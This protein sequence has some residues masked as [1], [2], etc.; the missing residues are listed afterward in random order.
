MISSSFIERAIQVA[1]IAHN[2]QVDLAGKPYILHP[3]RVMMA[4]KSIEENIVGVLHDVVEDSMFSVADVE[5]EFG[6]V[7]AAAVDALSRRDGESYGDFIDRC[8]ENE[9]ARAVKLNDI[10]DNMDPSRKVDDPKGNLKRKIR[11]LDALKK[12]RVA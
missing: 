2:G 8:A 3:L 12:L 4:G 11:Y 10:A 7:I 6:S 5:A 9:L 1:L